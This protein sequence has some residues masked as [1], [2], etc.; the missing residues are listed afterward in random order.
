MQPPSIAKVLESV[1]RLFRDLQ[2]VRDYQSS[3][4]LPEDTAQSSNGY[5]TMIGH[6]GAV[7]FIVYALHE[8]DVTPPLTFLLK[9]SR[10]QFALTSRYESGLSGT[11]FNLN[12]GD[13]WQCCCDGFVEVKLQRFHEISQGLISSANNNKGLIRD[14]HLYRFKSRSLKY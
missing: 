2:F 3:L 5:F 10:F 7:D 8:L 11:Y 13:G 14:G 4:G 6:N 9:A 12:G 1:L